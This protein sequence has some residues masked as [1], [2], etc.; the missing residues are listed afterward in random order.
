MLLRYFIAIIAASVAA[1]AISCSSPRA[2]PT[3]TPEPIGIQQPSP[4]PRIEEQGGKV[5]N[6]T[7]AV[8]VPATKAITVAQP[9]PVATAKAVN[10]PTLMSSP[11]AGISSNKKIATPLFNGTQTPIQTATPSTLT[12]APT[13]IML[14]PTSTPTPILAEI[15]SVSFVG[16]GY[17]LNLRIGGIPGADTREEVRLLVSRGNSTIQ[18]ESTQ[19]MQI[20]NGD[21]IGAVTV[22]RKQLPNSDLA[23]V[24]ANVTVQVVLEHTS[25]TASN[26]KSKPPVLQPTDTPQPKATEGPTRTPRRLLTAAPTK[27]S[28]PPTATPTRKPTPISNTDGKSL[29][30]PKCDWDFVPLVS[31]VKWL[32]RPTVSA[33]NILTLS[34]QVGSENDLILPSVIGGGASNIALTNGGMRL[35]GSIIPPATGGWNWSPRPGQAIANVYQFQNGILNVSARIS[36][37]TAS[38]PNLTLCLW[39]GG[40]SSH[41]RVL[42]CVPVRS[43]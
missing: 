1:F 32:Q 16:T 14:L 43:P 3:S 24:K 35:Y 9:T 31:G 26:I 22:A 28:I 25:A 40:N 33:Q 29:C 8:T 36:P 10:L 38:K 21:Y 27:R 30:Y 12:P 13:A 20:G 15:T 42:D 6:R 19:F 37:D 18:A 39:T 34:T 17:T 4:A 23:W 7:I 2:D 41:N 11:A 5:S